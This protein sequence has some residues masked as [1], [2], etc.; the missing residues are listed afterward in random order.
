MTAGESRT[1]TGIFSFSLIFQ[2]FWA[3]FRCAT[4]RDGGDGIRWVM[5]LSHPGGIQLQPP[6]GIGIA[7]EKLRGR[8]EWTY[9]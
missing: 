2:V 9:P 4:P 3:L 1:A 7:T 8:A 5:D 6:G